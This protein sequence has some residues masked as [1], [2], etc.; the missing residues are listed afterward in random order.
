MS[1]ERYLAEAIFAR[2]STDATLIDYCN[3]GVWQGGIPDINDVKEV[4]FSGGQSVFSGNTLDTPTWIEFRV[5]TGGET[6]DA[7]TQRFNDIT[8]RIEVKSFEG[9][10]RTYQA[11]ARADALLVGWSPSITNWPSAF[12]V[13]RVNV[14][15]N[16]GIVA[17]RNQWRATSLYRF[18][19]GT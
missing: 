12:K 10:L 17:N 6:H 18:Q 13:Q 19:Y 8:V 14:E 5:Q 4:V 3:G 1:G 2:L 7:T 9:A 15:R 16:G 11:D